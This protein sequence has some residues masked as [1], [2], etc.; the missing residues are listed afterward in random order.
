MGFPSFVVG[1]GIYQGIDYRSPPENFRW[2]DLIDTVYSV[3]GGIICL[4]SALAIYEITDE[5]PRQ[6]WIVVSYS[7]SAD[8]AIG[9]DLGIK[10]FVACSDGSYFDSANAFKKLQIK[11]AKAQRGL[12][13]KKKFSENWKKQKI[14][15]QKIHSKICNIR[16]DFQHKLSTNLSKN[17]AMIVTEALKIS[18]M[19]KSASGTI[20][21]PGTVSYTHL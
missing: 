7:T 1:R 18:N 11:L 21:T 5:I 17:H 10:K 19:S 14:K 15:I 20:E 3:P 16:R 13:K 6:H 9:I 8:G 2:D 12:S 4:V